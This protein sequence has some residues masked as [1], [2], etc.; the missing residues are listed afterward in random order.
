M[1]V[2]AFCGRTSEKQETC[3]GHQMAPKGS[4]VCKSCGHVSDKPGDCCDEPM[5]Q[6]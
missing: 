3:C 1:Y 6:V 2:C 4:Y 5:V